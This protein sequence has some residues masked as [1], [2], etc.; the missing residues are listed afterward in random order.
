MSL[1]KA[2]LEQLVFLSLASMQR[3]I[4]T[5][6]PAIETSHLMGILTTEESDTFQLIDKILQLPEA[7]EILAGKLFAN[8]D[9]AD[10]VKVEENKM[11]NCMALVPVSPSGTVDTQAL[12][13]IKKLGRP[14]QPKASASQLAMRA[15]KATT[16]NICI[17]GAIDILDFFGYADSPICLQGQKWVVS[18]LRKEEYF[19]DLQGRMANGVPPFWFWGG[20]PTKL[21]WYRGT[22]ETFLKD[23]IL[24]EIKQQGAVKIAEFI[25]TDLEG[26]PNV[27]PSTTN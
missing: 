14:A 12:E 10:R 9:L 20:P 24:Y 18:D 16:D 11:S 17:E 2:K 19:P 27:H 23:R 21:K 26:V 13:I 15:I 1:T 6:G 7:K 4:E 25:G 3:L 8:G 5:C 22:L